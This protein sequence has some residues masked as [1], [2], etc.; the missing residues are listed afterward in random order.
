MRYLRETKTEGFEQYLIRYF[1]HQRRVAHACL[2]FTYVHNLGNGRSS[3]VLLIAGYRSGDSRLSVSDYAEMRSIDL[4]DYSIS[5][6]SI[7]DQC[8]PFCAHFFCFCSQ[9]IYGY[10]CRQRA[11]VIKLQSTR[12]ILVPNDV[13]NLLI[14]CPDLFGLAN[15]FPHRALCRSSRQVRR[16]FAYDGK[17]K[18]TLTN[19]D[20]GLLA[21]PNRISYHSIIRCGSCCVVRESNRQRNRLCLIQASPSQIRRLF[22][23]LCLHA[24]GSILACGIYRNRS[25]D[26]FRRSTRIGNRYHL[27]LSRRSER[28][29]TNRDMRIVAGYMYLT[30]AHTVIYIE[31]S[32]R[33]VTANRIRHLIERSNRITIHVLQG[34]PL[35]TRDT[36]TR[37]IRIV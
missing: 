10:L 31:C 22:L 21:C 27:T 2:R 13:L 23:C 7:L 1:S 5:G 25:I 4:L 29:R 9:I 8:S 19:A 20:N 3:L 24:Q 33:G 35:S 34:N 16:S 26:I 14:S 30:R 18:S 12:E 37:D 15:R 17:R 32:R 6:T 36:N 28:S 11:L